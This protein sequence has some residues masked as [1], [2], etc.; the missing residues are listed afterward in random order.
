MKTFMGSI[1][2]AFVALASGQDLPSDLPPC[3]KACAIPYFSSSYGEFANCNVRDVACVCTNKSFISDISCC[4][5]QSCSAEDQETTYDFANNLCSQVVIPGTPPLPSSA[6][7][8]SSSTSEPSTSTPSTS[9]PISTPT[10][11]EAV[12][13]TVTETLTAS[14]TIVY[15]GHYLTM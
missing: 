11:T 5:A 12:T 2:L 1:L 3:A 15:R 8:S 10:T 4:I 9:D 13:V 6:S 14:C 7:C